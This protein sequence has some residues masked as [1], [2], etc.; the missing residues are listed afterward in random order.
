MKTKPDRVSSI[1]TAMAKAR[2]LYPGHNLGILSSVGGSWASD[3]DW[4]YPHCSG[5]E[6]LA[7]SCDRGVVDSFCVGCTEGQQLN[8]F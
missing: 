8:L 7:I 4:V 6:R 2:S 5:R 3:R 1:N